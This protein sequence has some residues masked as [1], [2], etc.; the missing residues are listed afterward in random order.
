MKMY[1]F[2][3]LWIKYIK[4]IYI[5]R[6]LLIYH[7]VFHFVIQAILTKTVNMCTP[8]VG[9]VLCKPIASLLSNFKNCS[10]LCCFQLS[11]QRFLIPFSPSNT[12]IQQ[13]SCPSKD[14]TIFLHHH[15]HGLDTHYPTSASLPLDY[16]I[17]RWSTLQ[18]QFIFMHV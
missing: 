13:Q 18:R 17:A 5:N 1:T 12:S 2:K 16:P 9:T 15:H 3:T 6:Y 14:C 8:Y 4:K 11:F 10:P 7:N